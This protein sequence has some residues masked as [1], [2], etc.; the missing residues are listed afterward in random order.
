MRK[1]RPKLTPRRIW[2]ARIQKY[3]TSVEKRKLRPWSEFPPR[4]NSDR[5]NC[6]N[7]GGPGSPGSVRFGYGL[8]MERFERFRFSVPA[9]PLRRVFFSV[10]QYNLLKKKKLLKILFSKNFVRYAFC[11]VIFHDEAQKNGGKRACIR[12]RTIFTWKKIH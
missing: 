10:F 8:G 1:P 6:Q 12:E 11:T 5:V 3:C 9:V 4:H 7:Q 2:T